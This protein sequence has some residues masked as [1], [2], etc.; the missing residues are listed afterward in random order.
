MR[1][2]I[3]ELSRVCPTFVSCYP[4]AGLPN[5]FGKYEETPHQM[6]LHIEDFAK[7]G[8][9]NLVGGCCGTSPDHI[10]SIAKTVSTIQ[11]RVP[12]TITPTLRISGMEPA[13]FTPTIGFVNVG[14]RCNVTGS[15]RFANLIK[16][17]KYDEALAVAK[18]QIDSGAI[19]LDINFDEALLDSKNVMSKFLRLLGADPQ[20]AKVPIMIDSSDFNVIEEGLKVS[21]GKCI[22]NSIS[23]KEGEADFIKKAKRVQRYGAAVVVMAFDEK[24]Q[25]TTTKEKFAICE[26]SYKILVEKVGFNPADI[27]FDPNILTIAT[28]I[29]EHAYYAI[30]FIEAVALIKKHLPYARVSGGVSNL[31]FSFRGNDPLREAMHSSFLFHA[32]KAGLDMGIVNAGA[33]PIYDDINPELLKL[34][35]DAIFFRTEDC[36]EKL[37]QYAEKAKKETQ[38]NSNEKVIVEEKWRSESV[39]ERLSYALVKGIDQYVEADVEEARKKYPT[40]LEVIEKPLMDGMKVV[41]DLFGAGKMFLPQVIKSARVMKKAVAVLIPFLEEEKKKKIEQGGVSNENSK[42]ILLATVKGDVHDIGKNIVG[43]VLQCNNHQVID[44]GVMTPCEKI[45]KTAIEEKVDIIGLS[46]LITPSLEEMVQVAKEMSRQ[47]FK[48]PLLIGGATTSKIHTAVKIAPQYRFPVIHVLDASR[49]A[50]VVSN[51]TNPQ[52]EEYIEEL[53][54]EYSELRQNYFDQLKEKT[55]L[56]LEKSRSLK[57]KT[58]WKLEENIPKE[59]SF[60]GKKVLNFSIQELIPW[61]DWNP[62]F[63]TWQLQ[64]GRGFKGYPMIFNDPKVGQEAKKLYDDALKMLEI[65]KQTHEIQLKGIIGF[66]P[67]NSIG[68][69]IIVYKDESRE[70]QETV[71]YGL[72]QQLDTSSDVCYCLS[73]FIATKESGVKDY[74]GMFAVSAGFGTEILEKKYHEKGDDYS[75]IMVKAVADRLAEA[76]AE[77]L[78]SQVRKKLWGYQPEEN[79]NHNDI[80]KVKYRGIRPASGYPTQPDHTEKLAMWKLMNIEQETGIKLSESLVMIPPASVSGLYFAHPQSKYFAV[81]SVNKEQVVDYA[82]RKGWSVEEAERHL[83]PILGYD[84]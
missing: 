5:A 21:Q 4:N 38:S 41:G 22:V 13:V 24:G 9:L 10:R 64:G 71:F 54:N 35:E 65:M 2:F 15:R 81:G 6:G 53:S 73:D 42:K 18:Q 1:P 14:E 43:V 48:V 52:R 82:K 68:D 27:I 28:G 70:K 12:P 40:P 56:T 75:V 32:I 11:P 34:V 50:V 19:I 8:F 49:A 66:Y 17:G 44:L 67:A 51:L 29:E 77:M 79:L 46:G 83:R 30:N 60:I 55:F 45:L 36:T 26:R 39:E 33:L 61:I 74:I 20:L 25:A 57:L 23:L 80:L 3:Q 72:R 69:D 58:N 62:F 37:L 63:G 59:P 16:A 47:G 78:H 84:A 31:S 7:S 76:I